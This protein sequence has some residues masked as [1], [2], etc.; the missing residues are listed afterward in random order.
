MYICLHKIYTVI[1]VVNE[2]RT[3]DLTQ[4]KDIMLQQTYYVYVIAVTTGSVNV[5]LY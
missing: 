4:D 5:Y 1:L 2:M 3:S